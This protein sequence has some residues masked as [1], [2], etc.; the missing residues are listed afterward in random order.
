MVIRC[1]RCKKKIS[2]DEAFAGGLCRCPYCKAI[3]KVAA[4][5]AAATERGRMERP[6]MPEAPAAGPATRQV[7]PHEAMPVASP[8]LV[9]GVVA[10]IMSALLLILLG[11]GTAAIYLV[12]RDRRG[13]ATGGRG[14]G[15]VQIPATSAAIGAEEDPFRL[16]GMRVAG[17]EFTAPVVFVIDASSGMRDC[18][19]LAAATVR[20]AIRSMG[21][22]DRFHVLLTREEGVERL[23]SQWSGG[24][25]PGDAKARQFF[26]THQPAGATDLKKGVEDGLALAPRTLVVL[27]AKG[28]DQPQTLIQRAKGQGTAIHA[29]FLAPDAEAAKSLKTL[30]EQTGGQFRQF[31]FERLLDQLESAPLLP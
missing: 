19:D 14:E 15:T 7:E 4:R 8:V 3:T 11:G 2:I 20:H 1:H 24:G 26:I 25:E 31:R 23:S 22:R 21:S 9:Q 30:A 16:P 13:G 18:Y 10:L 17:M 29:V 28:V 27:A 5:A 6:D 12:L